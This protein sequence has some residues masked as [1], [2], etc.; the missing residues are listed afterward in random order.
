MMPELVGLMN[1]SV[2]SFVMFS[3][4]STV[5]KVSKKGTP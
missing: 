3:L 1:S 2:S 5:T 4:V